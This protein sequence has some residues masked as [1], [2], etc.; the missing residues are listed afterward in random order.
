MSSNE[1]SL[2]RKIDNSYIELAQVKVLPPVLEYLDDEGTRKFIDIPQDINELDAISIEDGEWTPDS[3]ELKYKQ[4]ITIEKPAL[5]FGKDKVTD[6]ENTIG[7][8]AHIF[9]KNSKF[10]KTLQCNKSLKKTNDSV[11][12]TFKTSFP[13]STLRGSLVI[14]LFFFLKDI[15][16][17]NPFQANEIGMRLS[18]D[19]IFETKII[20]DGEGASFPITEED[21]PGGPLW[22][23]RKS[24]SDPSMDPFDTSSVQV[25]L[26]THHPLFKPVTKGTQRAQR[27]L[28][29][30][31][32]IQ[33]MAMIIFQAQE[34]MREIDDTFKKEDALEGSILAAVNY[35]ISTY[36]IENKDI[37]SIMNT[38]R[39]NL[40]TKFEEEGVQE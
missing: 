19:N 28:M 9:S 14:E 24:W 23:L 37:I 11:S 21:N 16:K 12:L 31:I 15:V 26:N 1:I 33:A 30:D 17:T 18:V 4:T 5:L 27:A 35:W 6:E 3:S 34:D 7:L 39:S 25:V 22:T 38:L 8:A 29:E 13:K 10:Q 32:M 2:Y 20:I 40:H 36:D